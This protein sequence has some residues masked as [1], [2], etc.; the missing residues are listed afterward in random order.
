MLIRC[1]QALIQCP[2]LERFQDAWPVD[3]Y[4]R[5]SLAREARHEFSLRQINN[6]EMD[7]DIGVPDPGP[8]L[9]QRTVNEAIVISDDEEHQV[10]GCTRI[11]GGM[12]PTS[13]RIGSITTPRTPGVT[14]RTGAI[15]PR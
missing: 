7:V 8:S 5:T 10:S 14:S 15:S 9:K 2:F 11:Q 1:L 13:T 6:D 12:I 3:V 4:L